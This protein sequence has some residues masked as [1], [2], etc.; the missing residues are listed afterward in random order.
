MSSMNIPRWRRPIDAFGGSRWGSAFLKRVGPLLD[1][2]LMRLTR[3]RFAMTFG[4][5]TLLLTTTGRKSGQPR[6]TPLLYIRHG[7]HLAVIGTR[8]G[9]RQHPAWFLNLQAN[10]IASVLLGGEEF[11]VRARD[12]TSIE[13][14]IIWSEATSLYGG[15]EKYQARVG[16]R[17]IPIVILERVSGA[18]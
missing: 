7:G 8:F 15:F 5:P 1:R 2:P 18:A 14:E 6:P 10:P 16:G 17:V 12:A 4:L 9:S 13:R 3:G 11:E